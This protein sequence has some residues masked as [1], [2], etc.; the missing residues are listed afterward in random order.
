MN[1]I[2]EFRGKYFFL[3]NIFEIPVNCQGITY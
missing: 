1:E 3:S 2:K